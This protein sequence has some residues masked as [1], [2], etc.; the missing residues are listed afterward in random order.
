MIAIPC[1]QNRLLKFRTYNAL[2]TMRVVSLLER[3]EFP[4]RSC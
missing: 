3:L 2:H 1:F 4:T